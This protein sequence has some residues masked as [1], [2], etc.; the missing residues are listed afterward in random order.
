MP[1]NQNK[2]NQKYAIRTKANRYASTH[3]HKQTSIHMHR[4]LHKPTKKLS[5]AY[6]HR[7]KHK[8][9]THKYTHL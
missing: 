1:I 3:K 7:H 9:I 8:Y 4:P 5:H 6:L 2:K